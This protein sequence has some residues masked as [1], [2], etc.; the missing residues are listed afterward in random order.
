[1]SEYFGGYVNG[2]R[3][4]GSGAFTIE[5]NSFSNMSAGG[6]TTSS[7]GINI[8]NTGLSLPVNGCSISGN[9]LSGFNIGGTASNSSLSN[10]AISVIGKF[11]GSISKNRIFTLNS[12]Q[13][14]SRAIGIYLSS[15][16]ASTLTIS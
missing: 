6:S 5:N 2:I 10:D 1:N 14:G 7:K 12:T 11:G 16:D 15:N 3:H 8:E 9:T 4:T 13:N